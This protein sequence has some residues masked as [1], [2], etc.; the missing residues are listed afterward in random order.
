MVAREGFAP[1]GIPSRSKALRRSSL[2]MTK[3]EP[4]FKRLL[5]TSG[6]ASL[7]QSIP[8]TLE[9]FSKGMISSIWWE[10]GGTPSWAGERN[11]KA[12]AARNSNDRT[13]TAG[14]LKVIRL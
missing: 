12:K 10:R 13:I 5:R 9:V 4:A 1:V 7:I 2:L 6:K 3:R 14:F 8:G 11:G